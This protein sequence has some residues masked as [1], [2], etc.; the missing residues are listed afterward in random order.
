[1]LIKGRA[2]LLGDNISGD[3]IISK[4]FIRQGLSIPELKPYLF[5]SSRPELGVMLGP[6]DI[7]VAGENFGC[8][9]SREYVLLLLLE[10]GIR[11]V[12]AKSFARGFYRA[13]IN[14]GL[15]PIA[16]CLEIKECEP[17]Q[18]DTAAGL[19]R[20]SDGAEYA[21]PP[22]PELI[23][24]IISEGGLINYYKRHGSLSQE[25]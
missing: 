6:E 14:Q 18:V 24:S 10:A 19:V 5:Y 1:M 20:T 11:C 16:C 2:R 13:C 9:S 25:Q 4:E 22:F 7:L 3:H 17:V 21:F 15:L 12:V 8:G 23:S